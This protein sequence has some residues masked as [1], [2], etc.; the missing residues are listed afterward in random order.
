[1]ND[2][3]QPQSPDGSADET[4]RS[5]PRPVVGDLSGA[6]ADLGTF[7]PLV[8]AVLALQRFNPAGVLIGFGLFALAVALIYRRPVPVQP[9]KVIAALIIAGGMNAETVAASGILMGVVLCVLAATGLVT[10]LARRV[11]VG[12]LA[13]VTVGVGAYL[14]LIGGRLALGEPVVGM[15]AAL[16]L[17]GVW[18]SPLRPLASVAILLLG[19]GWGIAR[20][21]E[22]LSVPALGF[23]LPQ[24]VM[25]N[26]PAWRAATVQALLPQLALT[27]TNA[28][29]VAASLA[30]AYFPQDKAR[31][32]P[33]RFAWSTGLLNLLLT[34]LGALPM[35]HGAG[36]LVV[37]YRFGARSALA[38]ALFGVSCLVLG[39]FFGDFALTLLQVI[40]L[41][42]VGVLLLVAG[43][44]LVLQRRFRPRRGVDVVVMVIT[45]GVCVAL[46]MAAGLVAGWAV[47]AVVQRW[48]GATGSA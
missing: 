21:P 23:H 33:Q 41:A 26:E 48:G 22:A 30:T 36:G 15:A 44:D 42:A 40:P 20:L 45:A 35:C 28:V 12:V 14:A 8:V 4:S 39:L 25:P 31:L 24:L 43:I 9:M 18:L 34:P 37:Q 5:W 1:M 46:N 29:L 32:S 6:F 13:G 11:P 2:H 17:A 16:L 10:L 3:P 38:P 7:L 47:H 27:L 19:V